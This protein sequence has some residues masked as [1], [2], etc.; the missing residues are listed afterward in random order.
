MRKFLKLEHGIPLH[1][2]FGDVFAAINPKEF[3]I[4]FMEWIETIR[5]KVSSEIVAVDGKTICVSKSIPNNKKPVYIVSAWVAENGLVLGEIAVKEKNNEITAIPELLKML[6]LTGCIVTI[7]A[8][9]TQKEIAKSIKDAKTDYVLFVKENQAK[10]YEDISLYFSTETSN[11]D[12]AK[13]VKKSHRRIEIRECY[14]IT[15]INGLNREKNGMVY[16]A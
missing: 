10:L 4:E 3:R 5:T 7:D 13:T 9:G 2:T 8:I 12:Y 16:L 11:C 1:D 6:E 14:S 15:D